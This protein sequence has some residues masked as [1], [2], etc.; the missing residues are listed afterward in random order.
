MFTLIFKMLFCISVLSTLGSTSH[1]IS[2]S[3]PPLPKFMNS[4]R[5]DPIP[6]LL[7]TEGLTLF[8]GART[9]I[10]KLHFS[11]PDIP[12]LR[13][14]VSTVS[15]QIIAHLKFRRFVRLSPSYFSHPTLLLFPLST[16]TQVPSSLFSPLQLWNFLT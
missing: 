11:V 14:S 5:I 1:T 16:M 6:T 13:F 4:D 10:R 7:K 2:A 12:H 9:N 3:S 15:L 8:A